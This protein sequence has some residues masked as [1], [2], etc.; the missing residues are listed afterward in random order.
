MSTDRIHHLLQRFFQ[1]DCTQ[2]EK[3]ELA[4][5]IDTLQDDE[6]WKL[7]LEEI[8]NSY[9]PGDK[10]DPLKADMILKEI[11]GKT[12]G[13]T[14]QVKIRPFYKKWPVA[15]AV[16]LLMA[17]SFIYLLKKPS[18]SSAG[19]ESQTIAKE[20]KD[21]APGGNKAILTL[22]NGSKV[23]LDSIQ[24][25]SL[26]RQGNTK[27]I[28][29]SNGLLTYK[30]ES[31]NL[32][33]GKAGHKGQSAVS[34]NTLSTPRGGQYQLVLPDGSKVWLNA[35]SS[36]HFPTA[37]TGKERKV[38]ISGE[39]YFEI[40]PNPDKPFIVNISS[41]DGQN[42]GSVRVLGTRF[43]IN[44]YNDETAV[45]STLL[46][47]SIQILCGDK[48]VL[49]SPG[50]QAAMNDQEY[51]RVIKNINVDEI[52]AWKNDLFDFEGNDIRFV[53]RQ[54]ARWYNVDV[55]Y[56]NTTSA[57]FMGTISRNV[58]VSQVLKML[59]MTGAVHFNVVG[60]TIIVT[61]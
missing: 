18:R 35:A 34:Y 42:K 56:E 61:K 17:A 4:L 7:R 41:P 11:I 21:I 23:I 55:K 12:K 25:G 8:W 3:E 51:I 29:V 22:A 54:I 45:R 14:D 33:A 19:P 38:E 48:A 43:N 53:M 24:N 39:A 6:E 10:M 59:E 60:R 30:A 26:G 40:A 36:L 31:L 28:K 5:W 47:G 16:M 44:S 37:F 9:A 27:V 57:H 49:L 46:E 50:E 1:E 52:I 20:M 15:A 2:A 32:P 58:N 13:Q